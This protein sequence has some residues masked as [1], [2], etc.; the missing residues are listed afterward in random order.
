V[1]LFKSKKRKKQ[2]IDWN[3][4]PEHVGVMMD[5]NG[6]RAT[7]RGLIRSAG[8][9][10]GMVRMRDFIRLCGE[11]KIHTVTLYAFSTENWKRPGR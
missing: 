4:M 11:Y 1:Y 2:L 8:H 9:Y 6:R 7:Q 5:R 10:A 3:L